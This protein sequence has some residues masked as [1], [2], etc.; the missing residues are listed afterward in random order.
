M[1]DGLKQR[2]IG[3][4]VLL[5]IAVIFVPV[6]F[7]RERITPVDRNTQIPVAPLISLP[8][9]SPAVKPAKVKDGDNKGKA[10]LLS[11]VKSPEA[12][13]VPNEIEVQDL[14]QEAPGLD[15]DGVAKAW[16]IQVASYKSKERALSIRDELIAKGYQAYSREIKQAGTEVVRV[17]VGPSFH[18]DRL[19][20][21]KAKIDETYNIESLLLRFRP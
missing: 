2:I 5:A 10:D 4:I 11:R 8:E 3:A 13:F 16:V 15:E 17:Y 9:P 7:D 1:N 19:V 6:L 12:I 18:K 14:S 20:V 21:S